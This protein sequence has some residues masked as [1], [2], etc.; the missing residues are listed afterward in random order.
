GEI[1]KW[2]GAQAVGKLLLIQ[3][4]LWIKPLAILAFVPVF[5]QIADVLYKLISRYRGRLPG[6]TD[7]CAIPPSASE[8]K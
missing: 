5:K 7:A 6:A 2:G 1:Q 4:K 8:T 3:P